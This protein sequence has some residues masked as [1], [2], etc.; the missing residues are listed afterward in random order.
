MCVC[1][2]V[3]ACVFGRG[4]VTVKALALALH[5]C[6]FCFGMGSRM[7]KRASNLLCEVVPLLFHFIFARATLFTLQLAILRVLPVCFVL[8]LARCMWHGRPT[9]WIKTKTEAFCGQILLT[10][11]SN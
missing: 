4:F 9:S 2:F 11:P 10:L 6:F 3:T 5:N 1:V 7:R 8:V